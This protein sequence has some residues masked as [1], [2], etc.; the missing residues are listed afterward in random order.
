MQSI[1]LR[2][3]IGDRFYTDYQASYT[4]KVFLSTLT[5]SSMRIR[6]ITKYSENELLRRFRERESSVIEEIHRRYYYQI[7]FFAKRITWDEAES[8]DIVSE[9]FIRLIESSE[10]ITSLNHACNFLYLVAR[11]LSLGYLRRKKTRD[12]AEEQLQFLSGH[13]EDYLDQ[14]RIT[15]KYFDQLHKEIEN[16]PSQ[17][18]KVVLHILNNKTTKEIAEIMGIS[19]KTVVNHKNFAVHIL[20]KKLFISQ[21]TILSLFASFMQMNG[22]SNWNDHRSQVQHGTEYFL[23]K[24]NCHDYAY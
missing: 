23:S 8:Q 12:L 1:L 21:F 5:L 9:A 7:F 3:L 22:H 4:R 13:G 15:A 14:E 24:V 18:R 10:K 6:R 20:R 2:P 17:P 19:T 16:L 11:N